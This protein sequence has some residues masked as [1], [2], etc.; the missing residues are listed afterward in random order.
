[1]LICEFLSLGVLPAPI[2]VLLGPPRDLNWGWG[3]VMHVLYLSQ[4]AT[5]PS[6]SCPDQHAGV[7]G[8]EQAFP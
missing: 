4:A 7:P 1:M 3:C 2:P 5:P 8:A 6:G